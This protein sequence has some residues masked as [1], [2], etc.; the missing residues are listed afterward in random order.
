MDF[1][2]PQLRLSRTPELAD[3]ND[4]RVIE[5]GESAIVSFSVENTG[6][7][8]AVRVV[9]KPQEI[10]RKTGL[11]LPAEVYIGDIPPGESRVVDVGIRSDETLGDGTVS[12]SFYLYES[13]KSQEISIVYAIGT[14]SGK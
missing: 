7:Y 4:N 9:V 8:P 6:K 12:L 1:G 14:S 11:V 2:Y 10:S 3:E 5:P 13:G